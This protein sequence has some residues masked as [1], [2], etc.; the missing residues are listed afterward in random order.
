MSING[1]R[2]KTI[3]VKVSLYIIVTIS[4]DIGIPVYNEERYI[5]NLLNHILRH[6]FNFRL[7]K[8]FV[9][10]S[11]CTDESVKI[12]KEMARKSKKIILLTE[13]KRNGKFSAINIILK[14][15]KGDYII[16]MDADTIPKNHALDIL[17][18]Y[19]KNNAVGVVT[20]K[21]IPTQSKDT[22]S[23]YFHNLNCNMHH[24]LSYTF[25][26]MG[27]LF[28]V[29]RGIVEEIPKKIINDDVYLPSKIAET[30]SVVYA[31]QA[32]IILIENYNFKSYAHQRRRIAQGNMQLSMLG[33]NNHL[34]WMIIA[35]ILLKRIAKEPR[36]I[37]FILLAAIIEI[38]AYATAFYDIKKGRIEYKWKKI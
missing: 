8:I 33:I 5:G 32:E 17:I 2:I 11:G 4:V 14:H 9:V 34:N 1:V 12:V 3:K 29:R 16:F 30:H 35:K 27:N 20:G 24:E 10:C 15:T 31:P 7:M 25:P 23:G 38:Y 37:I 36:K 28:V 19:F 26:R 6:K 21:V 18:D 13:K 22:L